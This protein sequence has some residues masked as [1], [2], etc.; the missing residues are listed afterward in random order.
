ML[1]CTVEELEKHLPVLNILA[2]TSKKLTLI[3][4]NC[5][6]CDSTSWGSE[7]DCEGEEIRIKSDEGYIFLYVPIPPS[8][9]SVNNSQYKVLPLDLT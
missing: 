5:V 2:Y 4:N 6:S 8:V 1:I 9:A 7:D 3:C